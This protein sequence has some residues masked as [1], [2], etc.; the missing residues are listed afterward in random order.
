MTASLGH[1]RRRA[2]AGPWTGTGLIARPRPQT[3]R[4]SR[5]RLPFLVFVVGLVRGRDRKSQVRTTT[6]LGRQIPRAVQP[7]ARP[8]RRLCRHLRHPGP[9][10]R[11]SVAP[12]RTSNSATRS[13]GDF[14]IPP[15]LLVSELQGVVSSVDRRPTVALRP[16]RAARLAGCTMEPSV[17]VASASGAKPAARP[18]ALPEDEPAGA[19]RS[20]SATACIEGNGSASGFPFD[21]HCGRGFCAHP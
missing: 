18:A 2:P 8:G 21:P 4:F 7:I 1:H 15:M 9:I 5:S 12:F 20:R 14:D 13:R 17:S 19:W 11:H 3:F 10:P 6:T 16:Y